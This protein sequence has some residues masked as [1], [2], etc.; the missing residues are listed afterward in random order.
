[1]N[2]RIVLAAICLLS[3]V[4]CAQPTPT[5]VPPTATPVPPTATP[6]PPTAT[7]ALPTPTQ[8]PPSATPVPPT[9]TATRIPSTATTVPTSTPIPPT[10][11]ITPTPGPTIPAGMGVLEITNNIGQYVIAFTI[12][13]QT[14]NIPAAGGKQIIY[15]SPGTHGFSVGKNSSWTFKCGMANNCTIDIAAGQVFQLSIDRSN[16]GN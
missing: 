15:L 9:P 8:V 16:Y 6:V 10:P 5:P 1:M 7:A 4:A 2:L 11:T 12:A 3:L 13:G 14:Y